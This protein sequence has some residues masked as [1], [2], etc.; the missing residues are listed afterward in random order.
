MEV[1]WRWKTALRGHVTR[2]YYE[3]LHETHLLDHPPTFLFLP[4]EVIRGHRGL[5][6]KD[7]ALY[8]Q[9][10]FRSRKRGASATGEQRGEG[11]Y[12]SAHSGT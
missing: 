4:A 10:R 3:V 12:S 1:L 6:P 9:P 11:M 2:S 5:V 8:T 7:V